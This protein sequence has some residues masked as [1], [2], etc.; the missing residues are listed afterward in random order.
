[1]FDVQTYHQPLHSLRSMYFQFV[2]AEVHFFPNFFQGRGE[3]FGNLFMSSSSLV[4]SISKV[5]DLE[6][7]FVITFEK[8]G[9][10]ALIVVDITPVK[11]ETYLSPCGI[12]EKRSEKD[13]RVSENPTIFSLALPKPLSLFSSHPWAVFFIIDRRLSMLGGPVVPGSNSLDSGY[14]VWNFSHISAN[15]LRS[16]KRSC[17]SS[18]PEESLQN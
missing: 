17:K 14:L 7:A 8:T 4:N 10:H 9:S 16:L 3:A 2:G 6:S 18:S 11:R 13:T 15:S 12:I 1:M 5:S